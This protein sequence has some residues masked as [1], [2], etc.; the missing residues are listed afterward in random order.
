MPEDPT[1]PVD[2]LIRLSAVAVLVF[3]NAFF[4]A[5]EFALV[6]LR[7]SR[8]EQMVADG[9]PLGKMLLRAK[10]DPNRFISAAQLGITMASLALGWI[11]EATVAA[12][13]DPLFQQLPEPL[14]GPLLHTFSLAVSFSLVTMLHIV[15]GEQVPKMV[16]LQHAE[17][18]ALVTVGP[19]EWFFRIFRPFIALFTWTTDLA[20]RALGI[21]PQNAHEAAVTSDELELM[22]QTS[23]R[24]GALEDTERDLLTNVFDFAELAV[25]QIMSQR[26][27]IVAVPVDVSLDELLDLA[28]Q[29]PH[30]RFPI[31]ETTLDNVVGM[32]HVKD[33]LKAA[34]RDSRAFN[35]RA[36]I[37]PALFVP[38]T[39][40]A[41]RL[42]S[43]FRRAHTTM[44]VV[45]DE[46]G[47]TAGLV[48]ID[49]V[50]EEI[51][52]D[53][54]D[55]FHEQT[56][57]VEPQPDGTA[58]IA[59]T[60]RLD[61]F[62][63][64][65]NVRLD[66]EQ[67]VDTVGGLVVEKLGRLARA[68]DSVEVDGHRLDVEAVEGVRISRLRLSPGRRDGDEAEVASERVD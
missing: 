5:A 8:I 30:S 33:A 55:E 47:G 65:F 6:S 21:R 62:A 13:V 4:V 28:E 10:D 20:L 18:T 1:S 44:A 50:V 56:P 27:D 17:R 68:G 52:G 66:G 25:Y 61:E 34:R 58:L 7:R 11:G 39:M 15:L 53:V 42:L 29:S 14:H 22:I 54:P 36:I 64:L 24:A 49:D 43:E 31:Y 16:A 59:P 12:L 37:R 19:T 3:L 38:E 51:V 32:V 40:S 23:H 67:E 57:S 48:T 45:I 41:G 63:E 35:V 9:H 2:V 46:Y 26:R 60:L